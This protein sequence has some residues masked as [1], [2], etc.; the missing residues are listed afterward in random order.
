MPL[1]D[2]QK[3]PKFIRYSCIQFTARRAQY[4]YNY[5]RIQFTAQYI[6]NNFLLDIYNTLK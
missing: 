5:S 6:Y 2:S 1:A 3:R 4:I